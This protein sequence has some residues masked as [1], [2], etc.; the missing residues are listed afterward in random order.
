[1]ED[2]GIVLSLAMLVVSIILIIAQL[3]LFSIDRTLKS[4]LAVL[5]QQNPQ[6]SQAPPDAQ[7]IEAQ[8]AKIAEVQK[9]WPGYK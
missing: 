2:L 5:S 6:S 3:R 1:M 4:I 8:R 7:D 9:N